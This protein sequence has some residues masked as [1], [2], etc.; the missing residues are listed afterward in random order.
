MVCVCHGLAL[1]SAVVRT[2]IRFKYKQHRHLIDEF[3]LLVACASLTASTII[4]IK[5][6]TVMAEFAVL[7][8]DIEHLSLSIDQ[9]TAVTPAF[10][11]CLYAHNVLTW[12][13]IFAVKF[14]YL[15]FLRSIVD[16]LPGIM[17]FWKITV[18]ISVI[19]F[20][21]NASST[22]ISCPHFGS[23]ARK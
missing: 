1:L 19:C 2:V 6:T 8:A 17:L 18:G 23:E 15:S 3:L 13:T 16:R 12:V 4:L 20:G 10:Q 21:F 14:S 22:F 11:N 9:T 5:Y 7:F